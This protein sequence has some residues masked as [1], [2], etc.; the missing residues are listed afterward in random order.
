[1]EETLRTRKQDGPWLFPSV[2]LS[3]AYSLG[4]YHTGSNVVAWAAFRHYAR[5]VREVFGDTET[6]ERYRTI[7]ARIK[8][9][10]QRLNT[11]EGPFGLQ[12]TEGTSAGSD[13]L[14][15][16]ASRYASDYAGFGMQFIGHLTQDGS[17]DLFH[18][19]GEE[20]DTILM[21]LYGYAAY[22]DPAYRHYMQFS[23]SPHN[24][25]YNPESRGIQWGDHA[26][27]TFPR[28]HERPGHDF[29]LRLHVR[30]GR[31]F[32]ANPQADRRRRLA[33]VVA[34]S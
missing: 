27:C 2:W 13:A 25:T 24:P 23:L 19:D 9:D 22:D 33:L 26:A 18:H 6:A 31:L 14:K 12:Y 20:S 5:I 29:R 34:L 16:D 8:D 15:D 10:L 17:I 28:L 3:D 11:V 21:P 30:N 4:D 1:M 7:A 32:Y